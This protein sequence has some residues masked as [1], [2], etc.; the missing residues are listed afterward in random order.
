M[1]QP[2]PIIKQIIEIVDC[3]IP[4]TPATT[5]NLGGVKIGTGLNVTTDGIISAVGNAYTA[6]NGL[7]LVGSDVQL[8]GTLAKNTSID[9]ST[10]SLQVQSNSPTYATLGLSN[11][12][13][14]PAL[15]ASSTNGFS[16]TII[17][18]NS[19]VNGYG[20]VGAA[21]GGFYGVQAATSTSGINNVI[22]VLELLRS[23]GTNSPANGYGTSV[24]YNIMVSNFN[25]RVSNKLIS[26]WT[27]ATDA[28]RTSEFSIRGVNA[29]VEATK[30]IVKGNGVVNI[31]TPTTDYTDNA[32]ALAGGLVVGDIYKTG[33]NLKI[34]H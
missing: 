3:V 27:D 9:G 32:A 26:K 16:G 5:T 13:T 31:P 1:S 30:F 10:F 29:G 28:T 6:S 25:N 7:S 8:G 12:G 2:Q 20:V 19:D 18:T 23:N 11:S 34:V 14:A 22:G 24:D 17:G 15:I 4:L 33:D 21:A